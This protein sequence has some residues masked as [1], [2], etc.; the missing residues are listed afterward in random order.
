[1]ADNNYPP[2]FSNEYTTWKLA[3][4]HGRNQTRT[5]IEDH[6]ERYAYYHEKRKQKPLAVT[7]YDDEKMCFFT[8]P[9]RRKHHHKKEEEK[10]EP[11]A[12]L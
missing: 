1:M 4:S 10:S 11:V 3:A 6:A 7:K 5:P 8:A 9:K 2:F 12:S